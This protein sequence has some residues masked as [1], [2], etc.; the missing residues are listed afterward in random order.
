MKEDYEN[1]V[2][3]WYNKL[4]PSF[5]NI[6]KKRYTSLS[7]DRIEDLYQDAFLATYQNLLNNK[8][9]ENTSWNSYIIKVGLNLADKDI[10]SHSKVESLDSGMDNS[11]NSYAA[12]I[13]RM[14]NFRI[15]ENS[16]YGS[17]AIE[18]LGQELEFIPEPCS[19]ILRFYY[20]DRMEMQNI[21]DALGFKNAQTAKAKK[22]RCLKSLSERV[23]RAFIS[24]EIV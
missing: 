16:L 22:Y 15:N 21:A 18:L 24:N 3:L 9:R 12:K 8:V 10:R 1:I 11:P 2:R 5:Q 13:E 14:M 17:D 19:S 6:L 4:K 20:Y 7:Y 23:K